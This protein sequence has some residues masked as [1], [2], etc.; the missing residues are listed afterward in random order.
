MDDSKTVRSDDVSVIALEDPL[1]SKQKEDVARMRASLLACT[2]DPMSVKTALHNIT[3]M[4]VY[5][6]ITRIIR[7]TEVMDKLENKLYEAIEHSVET[8]NASNP[9]TWLALL[10]IQEKL[11]KAMIESHK[12][13]QPY[14]D[15]ENLTF[16]D[17]VSH[18]V[19]KDEDT[20]SFASMI[21]DQDSRDKLRTSAQAVLAALTSE[22]SSNTSTMSIDSE[23][24]G[25]VV[26]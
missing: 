14:L 1:Y 8:L 20:T 22:Q 16:L 7:Y 11:Q 24:R 19:Q 9:S 25:D 10:G 4:R 2:R 18:H 26:E 13:L 12:L 17:E 21:L 15:L 5:H 3:V 6:Q 23:G